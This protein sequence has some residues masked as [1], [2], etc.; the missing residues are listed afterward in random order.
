MIRRP[1]RSTLFPYT[2]LF[3][4]PHGIDVAKARMRGRAVAAGRDVF[5][6]G[7]HQS[8]DAGEGG[9]GAIRGQHGWDGERNETRAFGGADVR[10]VEGDALAAIDDPARRGHGNRMSLRHDVG[11]G[12]EPPNKG[13]RGLLTLAQSTRTPYK[14]RTVLPPMMVPIAGWRAGSSWSRNS[15]P[16]ARCDV[17]STTSKPYPRAGKLGP[18][19]C[20]EI[21]PSASRPTIT[22][23]FPPLPAFC[24]ITRA[25]RESG[26]PR[27]GSVSTA[28]AFASCEV[29]SDGPASTPRPQE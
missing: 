4:S 1:P 24:S 7:E 11:G 22:A 28:R 17:S 9:S 18:R 19:N 12:A 6:T 2:T 5:T 8:P 16:I 21:L 15:T 25:G 10:R 26:I 13:Q 23:P 3:R 29:I 20:I 27:G 14:F